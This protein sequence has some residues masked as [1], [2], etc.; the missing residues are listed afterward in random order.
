MIPPKDRP[1]KTVTLYAQVEK[2]KE[3]GLFG[4]KSPKNPFATYSMPKP[5]AGIAL[6]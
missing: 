2:Q 6:G 5:S 4:R 3:N 1:A